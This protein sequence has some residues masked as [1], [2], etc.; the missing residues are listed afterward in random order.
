MPHV[1]ILQSLTNGRYYIGSTSN[2]DKRLKHHLGGATPSTKRFGGVKL[3]FSQEFESLEVARKVE[4]RL[5]NYKRK[6]FL[7]KIVRDGYI[8]KI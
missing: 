6:D 1:Y 7:Q 2:L 4:R 5:K 8:R 3:I